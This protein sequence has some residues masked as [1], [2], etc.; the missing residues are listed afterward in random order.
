MQRSRPHPLVVETGHLRA[1]GS[2]QTL[3]VPSYA[4]VANC[5]PSERHAAAFTGPLCGPSRSTS[6]PEASMILVTQS[7]QVTASKS[8][9][10]DQRTDPSECPISELLNVPESTGHSLTM[11]S[12]P[13]VAIMAPVGCQ[14]TDIQSSE[15]AKIDPSSC[16]DVRLQRR[17]VPS[18]ETVTMLFESGDQATEFTSSVCLLSTC[19]SIPDSE[20]Q[21]LQ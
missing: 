8:P 10:G 14:S 5:K 19:V 1:E 2:D 6:S 3:T 20:F 21:T 17:P 4:P 11:G 12:S 16:E 9:R 13:H 7:S 18:S 15:W